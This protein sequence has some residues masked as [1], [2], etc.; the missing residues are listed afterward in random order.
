L[1]TPTGIPPILPG[2]PLGAPSVSTKQPQD[3]GFVSAPGADTIRIASFNIQVFGTSKL[4]K[5]SVMKVLTQVVQQFDI[6]AIQEVRSVDDNVLPT[7]VSMINADGHHYDFVIGPR[8]GRTNSKEQYAIIFNTDRIEVDRANIYTVDDPQ[9]L[10][11]REPMVARFR[12]RGV[13][14][15]QAFTFYLVDIHTDPGETRTELDAL[16]DVFVAVQ[17]DGS[18]EDD[19][20][21]LGDLNVDEKHLGALGRVPNIAYAI[22]GVPTNT[23]RSKTY[24]NIVFDRVRTAEYMQHSGVLDLQTTFSLSESQALQ[25]SDH[26]P[27]WAEFSVYEAGTTPYVSGRP[28]QR[29]R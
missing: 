20:I 1:G 11:H 2:Y 13:P 18:G 28:N 3:G 14:P 6:V 29:P 25:V 5:S 12:V 26:C 22:A 15:E 24:D 17:N 10:L 4:Q 8:L 23:R 9:D 27:V 16:G 19:V 21:L 7:F